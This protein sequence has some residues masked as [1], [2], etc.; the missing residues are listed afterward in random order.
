MKESGLTKLLE[1]ERGWGQRFIEADE[2]NRNRGAVWRVPGEAIDA[3]HRL[4]QKMAEDP[5]D[6]VDFPQLIFRVPAGGMM[7][8]TPEQIS[9]GLLTVTAKSG[10]TE[11]IAWLKR[12]LSLREGRAR[13]CVGVFGLRLTDVREAAGVQ[14]ITRDEAAQTRPGQDWINRHLNSSDI[15]ALDCLAVE[16]DPD[17]RFL[18]EDWEQ[19]Q[20]PQFDVVALRTVLR[21]TAYIEGGAPSLG[22]TWGEVLHPDIEPL[23]LGGGYSWLP[24]NAPRPFRSVE[25][26]PAAAAAADR[27]L[28]FEGKFRQ[29]MDLAAD[30]LILSRRRA[31]S[32]DRS[33]DLCIA[34]E[35]LLSDSKSELSYRMGLRAGLLL[36]GDVEERVTIQ[37]TISKA[38]SLRSSVVHGSTSEPSAEESDL[39]TRSIDLCGRL[40][41][42]FN[43]EGGLPDWSKLEMSGGA[44]Y[45]VN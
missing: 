19:V 10:P 40:L 38:Y 35:A 28:Q 4:A 16:E 2:L 3:A 15:V 24:E 18:V 14:F 36:G 45:R 42:R 31:G 34:L 22:E 1:A 12:L 13:R 30:R 20:P 21:A 44:I 25:L 39:I 43:A 11:A 17:F 6:G 33:I 7:L 8:L 23:P 41:A 26:T 9:Q 37:R 27:H 29:K 5:L 32:A